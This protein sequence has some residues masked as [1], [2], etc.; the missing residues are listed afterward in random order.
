M[1]NLTKALPKAQYPDVR[2]HSPDAWNLQD[3]LEAKKMESILEEDGDGEEGVDLI[4]EED[5]EERKENVVNHT[6]FSE[7]KQKK[8]R[9]AVMSD[10]KKR[11]HNQRDHKLHNGDSGHRRNYQHKK[12]HHNHK[13]KEN[14]RNQNNHHQ[15]QRNSDMPIAPKGS[16]V[17]VKQEA[18]REA[19]GG[20]YARR[21]QNRE[22]VQQQQQQKNKHHPAHRKPQRGGHPQKKKQH[23]YKKKVSPYSNNGGGGGYVRNSNYGYNNPN[24]HRLW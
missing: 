12:H 8:K 21:A 1:R 18:M 24:Q 2:P 20:R 14:R 4:N 5:G 11:N 7:G 9:R 6:P 22:Q 23:A 3:Q 13:V 19:R 16:V 17:R 10:E 15:Q